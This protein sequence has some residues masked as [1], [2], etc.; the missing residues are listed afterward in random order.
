MI[1]LFPVIACCLWCAVGNKG[2]RTLC[3][4]PIDTLR[5][6]DVIYDDS[7]PRTL[8]AELKC[9][10]LI[11]TAARIGEIGLRTGSTAYI[12]KYDFIV[13]NKLVTPDI[14]HQPCHGSGTHCPLCACHNGTNAGELTCIR[15]SSGS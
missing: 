2:M 8:R 12:G 5:L 7:A 1:I 13:G 9:N 15:R 3:I 10:A 6:F 14:V 11:T 4:C